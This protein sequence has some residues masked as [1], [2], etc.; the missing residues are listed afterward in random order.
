MKFS[1]RIFGRISGI[2]PNRLS[3][4]QHQ[5]NP[6]IFTPH[7]NNALDVEYEGKYLDLE[8]E[9]D[10]VVD[11]LSPNGHGYI[12]AID[13]ENWTLRRYSLQPGSW[14]CKEVDPDGALERYH[15]E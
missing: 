8:P 1:L 2:D 9:L 12:D 10:L 4:I 11:V 3:Q 7:Q 15:H 6:Q 13:H 14:T 5:L